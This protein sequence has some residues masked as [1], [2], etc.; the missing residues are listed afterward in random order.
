MSVA[1][2]RGLNLFYEL[3][4]PETEAER[5]ERAK[6]D[7]QTILLRFLDK[8][9][10]EDRDDP[11]SCWIWTAD[12]NDWPKRYGRFKVLRRLALAHRVAYE[13]FVGRLSDGMTLDH[14]CRRPDCV[15]PFHLEQVTNSENVSRARRLRA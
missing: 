2:A 11:A 14:L 1:E 9:V 12:T 8:Y 13:I 4:R 3:T 10:R 7:Y 6:R 5:M 15:N